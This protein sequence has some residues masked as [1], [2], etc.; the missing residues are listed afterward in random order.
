MDPGEENFPLLQQGFEPATF[1]SRVRCSNRWAIPAWW[2]LFTT[3]IY[4]AWQIAMLKFLTYQTQQ[5]SLCGGQCIL[6]FDCGVF[7]LS[8]VRVVWQ[9]CNLT[10][11]WQF[12]TVHYF[13]TTVL[14]QLSPVNNFINSS[15]IFASDSESESAVHSNYRLK[16]L[17][18]AL[19]V[20]LPH[21]AHNKELKKQLSISDHMLYSHYHKIKTNNLS[22]PQKQHERDKKA[23]C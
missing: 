9:D 18:T 11:T 19:H 7:A 21:H 3:L 1:W 8:A 16:F 2:Q 4:G 20:N 22:K 14:Q 6:W 23:Q 13:L 5:L 15:P 10:M 17:H 12:W